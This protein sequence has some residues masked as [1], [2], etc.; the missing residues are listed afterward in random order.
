[1]AV[2]PVQ[3]FKLT[4]AVGFGVMVCLL[5]A[6]GTCAVGVG[7]YR[8]DYSGPKAMSVYGQN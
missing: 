5:V 2:R 3:A 8:A 7:L 1:M 4:L 6:L